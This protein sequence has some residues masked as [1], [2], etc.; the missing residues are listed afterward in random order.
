MRR[1]FLTLAAVVFLSMP[2][3][4]GQNY[5]ALWKQYAIA[6]EKDL[7][8]TQLS[9]LEKIASKAER[10]K[11]YGQLLAA[12]LRIVAVQTQIA[13]DS[14][15]PEIA[16]LKKKVAVYGG[17]QAKDYQDGSNPVLAAVYAGAL[18]KL[19]KNAYVLKN[20]QQNSEEF[21]AWA[22]R[23][24]DL[25]AA[26]KAAGFKPVVVDGVDS[27]IFGND[28]LHVLAIEADRWQL[29]R[30][31]YAKV[32]NKKA[33][34][35]L[36]LRDSAE[37]AIEKVQRMQ[38]D[39]SVSA[40]EIVDYIDASLVKWGNYQRMNILRNSR[41]GLM[42][43]MFTG[44]FDR[45]VIQPNRQYALQVS[46]RNISTL[47][48]TISRVS[49]NGK[50]QLNP[51]QPKDYEQ[52]KKLIVAKS[53][54]QQVKSF[55][56]HAAYEVVADSFMIEPL[57]CGVYLVELA[58]N[59]RKIGVERQLLYVTDLYVL[60]EKLPQKQIRYA[61][62]SAT[63]GLPVAGATIEVGLSGQYG[64]ADVF[65][66]LAT[67]EQGEV[68]YTYENRAPEQFTAYT[69]TDAYLP[70]SSAWGTFSYYQNKSERDIAN[71]YTDRRLYRPGQTVHAAML[72]FHNSKGIDTKAVAERKVKLTLRD[73]NNKKI[74]EQLVVTDK[75]GQA[76]ADFDLP[77]TGLTGQFS[78]CS[79]EGSGCVFLNVEEYKRPTFEVSFEKINQQYQA[80][81]TLAVTGTAK[82]Y[83]G[84]PV[85]N[86]QVCY[87]V[88]RQQ[89]YWW[90]RSQRE[91]DAQVMTDTIETD[92][93]GHFV[94]RVPL[95]M[96][97]SQSKGD[98]HRFYTFAVSA[99]VTDLGGESHEGTLSVPL[100][101]KPTAFSCEMSE[102]IERSKLKVIKFNYLNS[103]GVEIPGTVTYQIDGGESMTAQ[104]NEVVSMTA[105]RLPSGKH[106]LKAVCGSD[107]LQKDFV[108]FSIDDK[109]PVE[110]THDWF[111]QSESS[112]PRDG[113]PVYIQIGSSDADQHIL[114]TVIAGDKLL[115]SGVIEQSN[116]L[117][118]RAFTYQEAYGS[119]IC[120]T[121]AWVKEGRS[122]RHSTT[123]DRPLPDKQLKVEWETFRDRLTPGQNE[124]W[125]LSVTRPDG[126][127]ANAQLM[128]TLYDKSLD[129]I[130]QHS[131]DFTPLLSL[132]LPSASWQGS[133][134]SRW[135]FTANAPS[136]FLPENDLDFFR[137]DESLFD[138]SMPY[139]FTRGLRKSR[140]QSMGNAKQMNLMEA[141]TVEKS[142][143]FD[144]VEEM[145]SFPAAPAAKDAEVSIRENLT[146]TAFFYP[147]LE[148]DG[149]GRI[150][151]KFTLP[152]SVTTWKLLGLTHDAEM[153]YGLIEGEAVAQKK[154]M[155]QPNMPRFLRSGDEATIAARLFNNTE[156]TIKG[157]A[158]LLLI[159]PET[160][161]TVFQQRQK[162][163]VETQQTAAVTFRIQS[164]VLH[165]KNP[166][167]I[168]KVLAAG[169]GYS[170]G[171]QHYLPILPNQELVT[172][173]VPF[174][175]YEAGTKTID[176]QSLF[177]ARAEQKKV[178]VEYT[179]NPNWLMIQALPNVS[180]P[181]EKNAISLASAYYANTLA[182]HLLHQNDALKQTI[183]AWKQEEG[184][185]TSLMSNLQKDQELKTLVLDET[186]WLAAA[187]RE[188]E[189]KQQLVQF[190]DES[191]MKMRLIEEVARLQQLQNPD[192]SWCWWEGMPGSMYMT[193]TVTEMMVRLNHMMGEADSSTK[194]M[195]T[196]AFSFMGKEIA[197]EVAE[198]KKMEK[199]GIKNIRPS[200]TAVHYLYLCAL[201]GRKLSVKE[202]ANADYL[203][204]QLAKQT[205]DLSIYGKAVAAIVLAKNGN[206][207]KAK[208]YLQ[209]IREYSVYTEEMG[210][211]FDTRKAAYSWCDYKIPTEVA[212]IEAIRLLEPADKQ[213]VLEMQRWL[214]QSKRTQAWD[215]PIN[216][217]NAV[218]AFWD[219]SMATVMPEKPVIRLD[220]QS[221]DVSQMTKGTGYVKVTKVV[222]VPKTLTVQKKSRGTSWG[223]VYAQSLQT[224]TDVQ[225]AQAG[226]SVTRELLTN[227]PLKVG[228]RV[229]VR[230]TIEAVRDYDFVQ[231]QDKRAACLEPVKQLSGYHRGY[232][233]S[234]RDHVTNYYFDRM[235]KG[236]HVI[237]T[238]YYVDR[239][240]VYQTGTCT[241]QCA[242]SPEYMART[243]AKTLSVA[244]K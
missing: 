34:D 38:N 170:D 219:T 77:E 131:W 153:N 159:D 220:G 106:T 192:G 223:A 35:F 195:L 70:F 60:Q 28:L 57:P 206:E 39:K 25:L 2:V 89:A 91:S 97:A 64:K 177:P 107:T 81:D 200:E 98:D 163:E 228:D 24:P 59:N 80:G 190:F 179:N 128:A 154:V 105:L 145:P 167:Y 46:A 232:Y 201:D 160:N 20:H 108:V 101:T 110:T 183:L 194:Q 22:L 12:E 175:Q 53:R 18:G 178:T 83:S 47:T 15:S 222:K 238:E 58:A 93:E 212:A 26:Q 215:T 134:S 61:V 189:Q 197:K 180:N 148:S 112:F 138:I 76:N 126:T 68:I 129:Q 243:G 75:Y 139:L 71:I 100:G 146:E 78:I 117:C 209:S 198:M 37:A 237:E 31:Y 137:F 164:G 33:T 48:M 193:T 244:T 169:Q 1:I 96:D 125:R 43:P 121:Y 158:S 168:C 127:S 45:Q 233:I 156:N 86:A 120:L 151:I 174:T 104:A 5:T 23:N 165:A 9:V 122:Y 85:Q 49:V 42:N 149:Q 55:R 136:A 66:Q 44:V 217:I 176:L 216:T 181:C 132:N 186:P 29:L 239:E 50:T 133:H 69:A 87:Q 17:T 115:E 231:L 152:E 109:Q 140:T 240:G 62:V 143:V 162:Y 118:T 103:A 241:V 242:Y 14:L 150:C 207:R 225:D 54:S 119:G 171:E 16:K 116:S 94:V 40:K 224:I 72:L 102:K 236:K 52:L 4:Q 88:I 218:Y 230:L 234:P 235:A 221:L 142:A 203:V 56:G 173:T 214:L 99:V 111:Y 135:H 161:K 141:A 226:L 124:E 10:E 166:V 82:T 8:K 73:A 21:Y 147:A 95:V 67:D 204:G 184:K 36:L 191:G 205:A 27:K 65:K 92:G 144:V 63:T 210:R 199:E 213:T 182:S 19:Y 79:D 202:R 196:K 7:P 123:I 227:G 185:E 188:A 3:V 11:A 113:S 51:D 90:W 157:V 229:T 187:H 130:C 208:E 74:A 6:Q 13:P 84:I 41:S 32:G 114:Y 172:T 211:Y 155:I 30:D